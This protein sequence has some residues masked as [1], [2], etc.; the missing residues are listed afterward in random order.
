M[1]IFFLCITRNVTLMKQFERIFA[2]VYGTNRNRKNLIMTG[3]RSHLQTSK[4]I[5]NLEELYKSKPG[6][7]TL[8]S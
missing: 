1:Q 7:E 8:N 3:K 6:D 5:K 4:E 2:E